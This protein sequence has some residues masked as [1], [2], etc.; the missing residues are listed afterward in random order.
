MIIL[1]VR[2]KE[3][4]EASHIPN[5][6]LCPLS[7]F[8]LLIPGILKSIKDQ[9]VVIM[10]RSGKRSQLAFEELKKRNVDL[11]RFSVYEGG[12]LKWASEGKETIGQGMSFPV[13][14]QVQIVASSLIFIAFV[15]SHYIHPSFIFL[16][17]F[18]GGGLA[19]SGYTGFCPMAHILQ[20]MPW[21]TI[22]K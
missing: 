4:F 19:L 8:D 9:D 3:E 10:C 13:M 5:S 18:V 17:L 22:K 2:E 14:R 7:Q 6:I 12:I 16:A 11:K 20:R 1:D 21:N 15:L